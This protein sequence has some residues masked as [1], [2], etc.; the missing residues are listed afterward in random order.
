M[1]LLISGVAGVRVWYLYPV[2]RHMLRNSFP[3]AS[4]A[5]KDDR[6]LYS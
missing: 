3:D 4:G 2:R 1:A 5:A 6:H